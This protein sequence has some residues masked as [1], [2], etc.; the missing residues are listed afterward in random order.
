MSSERL[1]EIRACAEAVDGTVTGKFLSE[2]LA[3]V[4]RLRAMEVPTGWLTEP[5]EATSEQNAEWQAA[6]DKLRTGGVISY[7]L[8]APPPPGLMW[9]P[10]RNQLPGR[11][12][13]AGG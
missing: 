2:L 6:W 10:L 3:E 12:Y 13:P 9:Q 7:D 4:D 8:P 5:I 11:D 1:A